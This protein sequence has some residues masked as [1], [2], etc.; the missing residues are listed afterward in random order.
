MVGDVLR[1]QTT[2]SIQNLD[3][4]ESHG[5]VIW[6]VNIYFKYSQQGMDQIFYTHLHLK[7]S[8]LGR[9]GWPLLPWI[10]GAGSGSCLVMT[11]AAGG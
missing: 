6:S 8:M 2:D 7:R 10:R 4:R 9:W 1:L 11:D 3:I 5:S